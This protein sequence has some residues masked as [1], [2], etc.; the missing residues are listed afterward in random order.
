MPALDRSGETTAGGLSW[1]NFAHCRERFQPRWPSVFRMRLVRDHYDLLRHPGVA[2]RSLLDV[3]ATDRL[4]EPKA[5]ARFPGIDYRSFDIDRTNRHDYHDFRDVDRR[6]DVVTLIEVLEHLVHKDA[7][8]LVRQ[9]FQLC[10][11]GGWFLA[12]VPNVYTP[13]IQDEWTHVSTVHY[14]DLAGLL[15]WNGFEVVDGARVYLASMRHWFVHARLLHPLH[16]LLSVDYA[17]SVVMLA[18]KPQTT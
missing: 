18:R 6:F 8:D 5:R 17:Q 10:A 15:A 9:C 11:P 1:V 14:L 7:V 3:G 4:H 16:R 13:G 12:S 2:P